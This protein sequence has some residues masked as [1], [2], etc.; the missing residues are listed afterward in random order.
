MNDKIEIHIDANT[1]RKDIP[2]T[3]FECCPHCQGELEF[4]FGLAGGGMGPYQ[5]CHSCGRVVSK[6]DMPEDWS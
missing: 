5:Y 3:Q 6:S 2:E 4:G 1:K